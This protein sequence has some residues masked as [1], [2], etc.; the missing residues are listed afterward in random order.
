MFIVFGF[1][2]YYP[3]YYE[4]PEKAIPPLKRGGI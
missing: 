3:Q 2:G 4:N 1:F